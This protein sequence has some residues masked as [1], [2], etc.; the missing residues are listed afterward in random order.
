MNDMSWIPDIQFRR[1][2]TLQI[3]ESMRVNSGGGLPEDGESIEVLA[4]PREKR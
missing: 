4:L 2:L 3:D 1:A